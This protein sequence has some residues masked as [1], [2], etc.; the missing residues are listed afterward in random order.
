MSREMGAFEA[1]ARAERA[2]YDEISIAELHALIHERN[3]GRTG[4]LWSSLRD[5]STLAQS[6][7]TLLEV[8]ERRSVN[9]DA[10]AAAAGVL[11]R[12]L[13]AHDWSAE[14]L[15]DDADPE[16]EARL[17]EVRRAVGERLRASR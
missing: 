8:L 11:L 15:A 12:M 4:A 9:R 1:E 3:F 5:R 17:R 13:D 6:A 14:A 16:F 2:A 7:W 10:R